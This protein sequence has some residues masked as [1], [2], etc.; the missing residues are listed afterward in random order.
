MVTG[1]N[2]KDMHYTGVDM[3]RDVKVQTWASLRLASD[4]DGCPRCDSGT[5][6][7]LR[8][9]EVGHVFYLDTKYSEPM[10]CTFL[11]EAGKTTVMEMG[12][13]GIGVTRIAAAAIEQNSDV[14]G[15]IWPLSLAPYEVHVLSLQPK[16]EDCVKAAD[17]IYEQLLAAGVQ[18][19]YDDRKERTGAK[20]ADADLIGIPLRIAVGKRA[21]AEGEVEFKWRRDADASRLKL[22][23]AVEHVTGLVVA[24]RAR[25]GAS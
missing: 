22:D 14:R 24:E 3:E 2:E 5:F 16:D 6:E 23:A 18:V 4:G 13:Y 9:I 1:A 8:G 19:L 11:D 7:V 20:F 15:I 21:L 17:A 12:C 10:G 25:L